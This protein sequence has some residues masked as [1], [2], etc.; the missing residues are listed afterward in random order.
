MTAPC[1]VPIMAVG[2]DWFGR[3]RRTD[4]AWTSYLGSEPEVSDASQYAS[5]ARRADL[6]G[7][8]PAWIGVGELDL[9]YDEDIAYSDRLRDCG[10]SCELITV[11]AM[12]HGAN[13]FAPEAQSMKDFHA[14][15]L[16][17]LRAHL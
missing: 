16:N 9:F 8:P 2:D 3:R 4:S 11:P 15:M 13:Y 6:T 1:C 7:L 14:S 17:H 5:P 10:V 12:Y